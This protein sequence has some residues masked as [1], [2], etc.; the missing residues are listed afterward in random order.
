[1]SKVTQKAVVFSLVVVF[2]LVAA[3][4][5]VLLHS[6]TESIGYKCKYESGATYARC[7]PMAKDATGCYGYYNLR[8]KSITEGIDTN[9]YANTC[10]GY[11]RGDGVNFSEQGDLVK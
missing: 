4:L 3:G 10:E 8:G 6:R 7:L 2:F 5:A 9:E 11:I 1:M